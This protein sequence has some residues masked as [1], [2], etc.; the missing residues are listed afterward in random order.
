MSIWHFKALYGR[1]RRRR[2]SQFCLNTSR[3]HFSWK[4]FE[5]ICSFELFWMKV[6]IWCHLFDFWSKMNGKIFHLLMFRRFNR[7]CWVRWEFSTFQ[8]CLEFV[9]KKCTVKKCNK[10]YWLN[11]IRVYACWNFSILIRF[12]KWNYTFETKNSSQLMK[13]DVQLLWSEN[14]ACSQT[15]CF[16]PAIWTP[17]ES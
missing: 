17:V 15:G 9:R 5:K 8:T 14:C 13:F 1:R 7:K 16:L 12:C 4:L 3:C 6:S 10:N 2:R 11:R